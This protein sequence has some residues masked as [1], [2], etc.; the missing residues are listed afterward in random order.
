MSLAVASADPWLLPL[1]QP[2]SQHLARE[3]SQSSKLMNS[4]R[5]RLLREC[6]CGARGCAFTR[7]G[8]NLRHSLLKARVS[9]FSR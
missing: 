9:Q 6:H 4:P 5:L 7:L 2:R 8:L 1:R 3:R